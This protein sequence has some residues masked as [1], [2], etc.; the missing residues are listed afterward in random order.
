MIGWPLI[1]YCFL[2]HY[3]LYTKEIGTLFFGCLI[4]L[5][6][7]YIYIFT[8]WNNVTSFHTLPLHNSV[9]L[10]L[11]RHLT[12]FLFFFLFKF[13]CNYIYQLSFIEK[14]NQLTFQWVVLF[15]MEGNYDYSIYEVQYRKFWRKKHCVISLRAYW[16]QRL[17]NAKM[18]KFGFE[19]R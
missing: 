2:T 11:F 14:K 10:S 6:N 16:R 13:P 8:L 19:E 5:L 18:L 7:I 15:H 9:S 17:G 12:R 3:T 4:Y 1:L